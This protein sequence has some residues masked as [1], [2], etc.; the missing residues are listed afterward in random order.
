[1]PAERERSLPPASEVGR[2]YARGA[3]PP[4]GARR[5]I[6]SF[7]YLQ[8]FNE[9]RIQSYG[10]SSVWLSQTSHEHLAAYD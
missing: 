3:P 8:G 9:S 4:S 7:V 10:A 2:F 6:A 5:I 1:M